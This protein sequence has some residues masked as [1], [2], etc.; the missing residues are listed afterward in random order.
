ML[1]TF[2][3]FL[4]DEYAREMF[5][6]GS[7]GT[8]KTTLQHEAIEYCIANGI[9]YLAC[10]FTHKACGILVS[11]L[12]EGAVVSTLHSFLKKRPTVNEQAKRIQH[13]ESSKVFGI[14]EKYDV[15][16][17]DEYSQV[18]ERDYADIG[19]LQ[20]SED[21]DEERPR[22]KVVYIGD[23]LQLPPVGDA[24]AVIPSGPYQ[25]KLTKVWRQ[26]GDN[27][28][29]DT[30]TA[31]VSLIGGGEFV[32]IPEHETFIRNCDLIKVW[33]SLPNVDKVLLAYT[34]KRVEE[35][36]AAVAGK[37]EPDIGDQLYSPTLREEL[38]LYTI[39]PRPSVVQ[40]YLAFGDDPLLL[41][42]KYKTL[43]HLLKMDCCTFISDENGRVFATVFGHYQYLLAKDKYAAAAVAANKQIEA[44][45]ELPPKVWALNNKK[46]PLSIVRAKA[47]RDYLTFKQCVVCVDFPHAMTVHKSQGST[48]DTVLLDTN[49]LY[50]CALKDYD[51]YLK[52]MYV[53]I[54]RASNKVYTS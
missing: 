44:V 53:G 51:L 8:G 29:L 7:A 25:I 43:E 35:L 33:H 3:A 31:L 18:G 28:L 49:D 50:K 16:F 48:Y 24:Q 11:K 32:G 38:E 1:G 46:H 15:I 42:S 13:L 6:T 52:L 26:A 2:K 9:K 10:A 45:T 34:N 37:T 20:D 14:A 23:P 39:V 36:N 19:L 4:E 47:W 54:S 5:V 30:M 22:L 41:G 27:K 21:P 12:P 17:V 40:I